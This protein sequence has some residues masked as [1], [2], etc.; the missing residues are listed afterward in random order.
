MEYN[1][2]DG[3]GNIITSYYDND[4]LLLFEGE[5]KNGV[6]NGRGKEYDYYSGKLLFEG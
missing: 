6:K 4:K 5:Y 1:L 2:K 3:K